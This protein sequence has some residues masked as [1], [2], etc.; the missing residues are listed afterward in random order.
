MKESVFDIIIIG[1]SAG[2]I[3]VIIYL[4]KSLPKT[5]LTPVVLVIHRIKNTTSNLAEI[6]TKKTDMKKIIEPEDKEPIKPGRIYLAPQNYHLL[7]EED[8]TFSLDYS[9]Q[10]NF[11]RPSIDTSFENFADIYSKRT[12]AILLSGANKDGSVGLTAVIEKGG[13]AVVQSPETARYPTMPNAAIE[14]NNSVLILN[15]EQILHYI[16]QYPNNL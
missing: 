2:S 3:E 13:M 15:P 5:F 12:L 9:E 1:G 11:S 7:V 4:L 14:L 6:L 16:L 10:V 8:H